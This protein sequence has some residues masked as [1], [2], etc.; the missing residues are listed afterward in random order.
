MWKV[1]SATFRLIIPG[2]LLII[3][4]RAQAQQHIIA[5][6]D[7]TRPEASEYLYAPA[8]ITS[9]TATR[10][11]GSNEIRW[12]AHS[13]G[14]TRRYIV[15][16]SYNGIDFLSAGEAVASNGSYRFIHS[17]LDER[18]TLY[19]IRIEG[20]RSRSHFSENI[21][22]DGIA[23]APVRIYPTI[24]TTKVVN[25]N[26]YF[27]VERVTVV[28]SDAR[29]VFT[30]HLNGERD[31]IPLTIPELNSGLYFITFYG[32]GWQHTTKFMVS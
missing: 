31:F 13:E 32:N 30:Q 15:E 17:T 16:Y 20:L 23:I 21:Y 25:V 14:D 29:Q 12:T 10:S 6:K 1:I 5:N 19:R 24:V 27:P 7:N 26:A 28:S 9:F 8:R 2:L 22:L 4:S 18:P 11:N 3:T